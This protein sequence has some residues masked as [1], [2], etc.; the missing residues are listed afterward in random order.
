M[1]PSR[2]ERSASRPDTSCAERAFTLASTPSSSIACSTAFAAAHASGLPPKVDACVPGVRT[3]HDALHIIAPMGTPPPSAFADVSTSTSTPS[4]WCPQKAPERQTPLCTSSTMRRASCSSQSW[5]AAWKKAA[6]PGRMP[7]SPCSGSSRIAA[8]RR[9]WRPN[10]SRRGLVR[11]LTSARSSSTSLY[12]TY[13]NPSGSGPNPSWYLGWP[14]AVRV[15]S[16]RPWKDCLAVMMM[17][18][19][20]PRSEARLRASLIAPSLAS[21]PE[22][23]KKTLS[24]LQVAT[25]RCASSP[26]SGI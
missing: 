7:P 14:V 5:R 10:G 3:S 18:L 22:L 25:R 19:S 9:G 24:R 23:Q 6:S 2:L 26:C 20:T 17:G 13:S 8:R 15:A 12:S 11:D 4:L 16:V 21:A 1:T